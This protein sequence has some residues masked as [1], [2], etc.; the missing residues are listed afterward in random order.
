ME[1]KFKY[2]LWQS[3]LKQKCDKINLLYVCPPTS[4]VLS[5]VILLSPSANAYIRIFRLIWCAHRGRRHQPVG[6]P[7]HLISSILFR[8]LS[9]QFRFTY[10]TMRPS[11]ILRTS[12]QYH[13]LDDGEV[14]FRNST[15][16]TCNKATDDLCNG[17]LLLCYDLLWDMISGKNN[18][19]KWHRRN[20]EALWWAS[21]YIKK[22][23]VMECL[24]ALISLQQLSY[25]RAFLLN[26]KMY[27][28][29]VSS[30]AISGNNRHKQNPLLFYVIKS[31]HLQL[32]RNLAHINCIASLDLWIVAA[33]SKWAHKFLWLPQW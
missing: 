12:S 32:S 24:K 30:M 31:S 28:F 10:P 20:S 14:R 26:N 9:V 17:D 2:S 19:I 25:V 23:L 1:K 29:F 33:Q 8:N 27:V 13:C 22:S 6:V 16:A 3:G 18:V 11:N 7:S 15:L 5:I 4:F 21:E